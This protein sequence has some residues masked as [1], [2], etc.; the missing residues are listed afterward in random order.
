MSEPVSPRIRVRIRVSVYPCI[1]VSV[2][3]SESPCI[4]VSVSES[5]SPC[6]RVS[7]SESESPCIRVSVSESVSESESPRIRVSVYPCLRASM[8]EPESPRIRVRIRVVHMSPTPTLPVYRSASPLQSLALTTRLTKKQ[9][10]AKA[11]ASPCWRVSCPMYAGSSLDGSGPPCL[12]HVEIENC[13]LSP[14]RVIYHK[15]SIHKISCQL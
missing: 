5:E 12:L 2:S 4:R 14:L 15:D 1:R 6:I 10:R 11:G 8:S 3:E 7:V 9:K 13:Q